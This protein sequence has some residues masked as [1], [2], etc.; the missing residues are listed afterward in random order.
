MSNNGVKLFG[1]NNLKKPI[2]NYLSKYS[3][4]YFNQDSL[5]NS[6]ISTNGNGLFKINSNNNLIY[7]NDLSETSNKISKFSCK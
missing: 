3:V 7:K 6:W 2:A 5:D 4:L 1:S